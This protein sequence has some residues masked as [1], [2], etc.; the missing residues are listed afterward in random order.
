MK[1]VQTK[2]SA[3]NAKLI[4][5]N[6]SINAIQNVRNKLIRLINFVIIVLIDVN[7]VMLF[8]VWNVP[9]IWI[10]LKENV[11]SNALNL[12]HPK[13]EFVRN[14]IIIAYYANKKMQLIV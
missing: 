8:S 9:K 4:H 13:K 10:Y 11:L 2:V 14:A 5:M 3:W 12:L 1:Y 7:N 6:I